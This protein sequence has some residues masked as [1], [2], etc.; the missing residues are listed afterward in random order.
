MRRLALLLLLGLLSAGGSLLIVPSK[1]P[2]CK[3]TAPIDLEAKIVGDPSAPFGLV[4]RASSRT[5]VEVDLEIILP[6]GITPLAGTRK[7][8]GK[9]CEA[10]LD[11]HAKDRTRREILVSASFTEGGARL[12][13]V[14]SLVLFDQPLPSKG[15][16]ATDSRG[17]ALLEFS[18]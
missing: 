9:R 10:R 18:P 4:A 3:P 6:E 8:K 12:T 13:R 7:L 5:G 17:N 11:L 16:P 2:S 14:V 15:T 1:P